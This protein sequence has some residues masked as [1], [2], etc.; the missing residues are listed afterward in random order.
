MRVAVFGAVVMNQAGDGTARP[1]LRLEV[2]SRAGPS[3]FDLIDPSEHPLNHAVRK[4][5]VV[6]L[7]SDFLPFRISPLEELNQ[8]LALVVVLL[9]RVDEQPGRGRYRISVRTRRIRHRKTEV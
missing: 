8:L 6:E 3:I 1:L 4:R 9:L 7:G 2:D 5:G